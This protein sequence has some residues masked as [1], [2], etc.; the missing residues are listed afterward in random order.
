MHVTLILW[1]IFAAWRWGDWKHWKKYHATMLFMALSSAMYDVLVNDGSYY[2]WRY[3]GNNYFS[4]EM[5]SLLYTCVAFPATALL[6]LSNFPDERWQQLLHIGKYVAIYV[7]LEIIGLYF[8]T[9]SHAHSWNMWWSTVFNLAMFSILRLHFTRPLIAYVVS[10]AI[11]TYLMI[12]F[13]VS[14]WDS[15]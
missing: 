13:Q 11:A 8:G 15:E 2:L 1:S 7:C 4:E 9:I 3:V 10:L 14:L 5:A 6:F 12:H